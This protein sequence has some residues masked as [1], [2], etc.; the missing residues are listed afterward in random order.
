MS[1]DLVLR[2]DTDASEFARGF[3]AGRI[4]ERIRDGDLDSLDGQLFH[5]TNAEMVLR[6]IESTEVTLLAEHVDDTWM[7]LKAPDA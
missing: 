7:V 6:M 4:W 5:A 1:Y 2:F 3:E